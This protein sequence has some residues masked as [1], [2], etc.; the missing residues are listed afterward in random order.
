M[1]D[2]QFGFTSEKVAAEVER[3]CQQG[4]KAFEA[5]LNRA[6]TAEE[7][8]SDVDAR[9]MARYLYQTALG[10]SARTTGL[11]NTDYL[12]ESVAIALA[13]LHP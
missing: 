5:A 10:L 3:L 11:P 8:P 13:V 2:D 1:L 6:I 12:R 7:L 9:K 4:E